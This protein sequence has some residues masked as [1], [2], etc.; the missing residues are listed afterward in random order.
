MS[1][2]NVSF[3]FFITTFLSYLFSS[4]LTFHTPSH[5]TQVTIV[6]SPSSSRYRL[7]SD[8]LATLGAGL[9]LLLNMLSKQFAGHVP[10]FKA[11]FAPPLPLT[12]YFEIIERH[13]RVSELLY[14]QSFSR[15][16]K[17]REF[18]EFLQLHENIIRG[19]KEKG[20]RYNYYSICHRSLRL[21]WKPTTAVIHE[22]IFCEIH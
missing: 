7:Q 12:E 11:T 1:I 16:N 18:H 5:L 22:N 4:P 19:K 20:G 14:S 10:A 6:A 3:F 8:S 9:E 15:E 13:Y 17:F 21:Y 2:K